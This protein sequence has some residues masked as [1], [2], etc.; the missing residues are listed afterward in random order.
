MTPAEKKVIDAARDWAKRKLATSHPDFG[1]SVSHKTETALL[2]T[3]EALD[4]QTAE[5]APYKIDVDDHKRR[6]VDEALRISRDEPAPTL[7]DGFEEAAAPLLKWK[8]QLDID[9]MKCGIP[10]GCQCGLCEEARA[11]FL[12]L[13]SNNA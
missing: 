6:E 11:S 9:H 4:A 2:A 8:E 5:P 10:D 13:R 7:D 3:V 12:W 1:P